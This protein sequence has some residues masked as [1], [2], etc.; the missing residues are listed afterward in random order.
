[1][2][3]NSQVVTNAIMVYCNDFSNKMSEHFPIFLFFQ[4]FLSVL[5]L[6][7]HTNLFINFC[8]NIKL[9]F[10]V[11]SL[12]VQS[13]QTSPLITW[14]MTLVSTSVVAEHLV[15]TLEKTKKILKAPKAITCF[16]KYDRTMTALMMSKQ[17]TMHHNKPLR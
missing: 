3:M 15:P 1:M 8:Y 17:R 14:S 16:S 2:S 12:S 10:I 4:S 11:Y 5:Y 7:H 13:A 6:A 9:Y